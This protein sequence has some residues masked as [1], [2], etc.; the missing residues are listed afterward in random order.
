MCV[1]GYFFF[2]F[3]FFL[4]ILYIYIFIVGRGLVLQSFDDSFYTFV[5]TLT[6]PVQLV[7]IVYV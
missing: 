4:Y 1:S 3:Q 6:A 5:L 7:T 2:F